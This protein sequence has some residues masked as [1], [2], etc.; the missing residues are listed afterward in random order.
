MN[1]I[2]NLNFDMQMVAESIL[3]SS[4]QF[5]IGSVTMSSTFSVK[6]FCKDQETLQNAH[7][8]LVDYIK[9]G[10]YWTV[11]NMILLYCKYGVMGAIGGFVANFS[12]ILWMYV[13][14]KHAFQFSVDTHKLV[15]PSLF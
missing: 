7:N 4:I 11:G 9:I 1:Y 14:Y 2:K 3:Y 10:M 5:A 12:I 13:N 8:A 6:N 15:M